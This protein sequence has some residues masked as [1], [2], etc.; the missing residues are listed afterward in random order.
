MFLLVC[1]LVDLL[2]RQIRLD[3]HQDGLQLLHLLVREREE[4]PE[5]H[6]V[7]DHVRDLNFRNLNLLQFQRNDD[8][9]DDDDQ[10]P[11]GER[12]RQRSRSRERAPPHAGQQPQL[13]A[14]PPGEQQMQV[15]MR[16]QQPWK[17]RIA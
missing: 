5:M 11:Q 3:F 12:Q 10:P 9:D 17:H 1:G 16:S 6:R 8:D 4:E 15:R 2:D 14:P 13:V 7:S